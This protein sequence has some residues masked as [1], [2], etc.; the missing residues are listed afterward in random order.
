MFYINCY[1]G[2]ILKYNVTLCHATKDVNVPKRRQYIPFSVGNGL[3][4]S[5]KINFHMR[6]VFKFNWNQH[7]VHTQD[8]MYPV[9]VCSLSYFNTVDRKYLD[10]RLQLFVA[11]LHHKEMHSVPCVYFQ[12]HSSN[13]QSDMCDIFG[14]LYCSLVWWYV[15][16]NSQQNKP[17]W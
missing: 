9:Q 14:Y 15:N 13:N 4:S 16:M 3:F 6:H 12:I 2:W 1:I 11:A 5:P 17:Y 10:S 7:T 8:H